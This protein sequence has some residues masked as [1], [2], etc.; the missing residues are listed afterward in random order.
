MRIVP[1]LL[2]IAAACLLAYKLASSHK[3]V[4]H[5]TPQSTTAS[6]S[7]E[8]V[9]PVPSPGDRT[10]EPGIVPPG[11]SISAEDVLNKLG[12]WVGS[13]PNFHAL[14]ETTVFGGGVIS[15][16]DMFAFT[17]AGAGETIKVK[18][19]FFLPKVLQF[20]A[21]K[22][23][24][25]VL[26]YFPLSRLLLQPD[27]PSTLGSLPT[28]AASSSGI[29]ALLN[30]SKNTFAEASADLRVVTL[31]LNTEALKLPPMSGDIYLS[32]RTDMNGQLL[33]MEQQAMGSRVITTVRYLTFDKAQVV[34]AAPSLPAGLVA[35]T[36]K[37]LKEAM[38]E[39]ARLVLNKPLTG[40]KI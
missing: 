29:G 12:A 7:A 1:A 32:I 14:F 19:D 10:P 15:K 16:M 24:G 20:Q 27:L 28:L 13:H 5:T 23:N 33:G 36:G 39:E 3:L 31:T 26:V 25:K 38:D 35:V 8:V 37:S 4:V 18:A 30:M 34:Q 11:T 2:A 17:N 21:Q 6:S 9:G 22:E 40:N